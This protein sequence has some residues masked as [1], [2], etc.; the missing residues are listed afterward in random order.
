[1]RVNKKKAMTIALVLAG[2]AI[3]ALGT[4]MFLVA[5]SSW[6]YPGH[7]SGY[8]GMRGPGHFA[9]GAVVFLGFVIFAAF[10]VKRRHGGDFGWS[11]GGPTRGEDA[12]AVLR[13]E[14]AEGR[15]S[16]DDYRHRLNV[17]EE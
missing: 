2:L 15:I 1:M 8:Y 12:L 7:M 6:P 11:A 16:E 14:F 13:R 4:T 17:L 5:P 10:I 9:G 3:V